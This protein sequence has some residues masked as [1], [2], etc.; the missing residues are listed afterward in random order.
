MGLFTKVENGEN[1]GEKIL[2]VQN[3]IDT[4]IAIMDNLGL[5]NTFK[6][7]Q[8]LKNQGTKYD[9]SVLNRLMISVD[10]DSIKEIKK[11]YNPSNIGYGDIKLLSIKDSLENLA[12]KEIASGKNNLEVVEEL[13]NY[14][15]KYIDEYQKI[16]IE[17]DNIIKNLEV[18][19]NS[20]SELF[21]MMEYW[22]NNFKEEKLGY[23]PDIDKKIETLASKL[24][25]LPYGGY[26]DEKVEEFR[27]LAKQMAAV[28]KNNNERC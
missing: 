20:N 14:S 6:I 4:I 21:A 5:L 19:C 27:D 7:E 2:P 18:R 12:K 3:E 23:T 11:Y 28:K 13:I 17:F 9:K 10:E 26:G 25:N 8:F 1:E 15:K 22:Y 24:E 16:I